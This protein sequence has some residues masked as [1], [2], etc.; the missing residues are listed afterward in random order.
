MLSPER[1]DQAGLVVERVW[2]RHR[3]R[4]SG[5]HR[6]ANEPSIWSCK[7]IQSKQKALTMVPLPLCSDPLSIQ[8]TWTHPGPRGT[9]RGPH[10]RR[11]QVAGCGVSVVDSC[12]SVW[13]GRAQ[14]ELQNTTDSMST[15]IWPVA[16]SCSWKFSIISTLRNENSSMMNWCDLAR[17]EMNGPYTKGCGDMAFRDDVRHADRRGRK[18]RKWGGTFH[19]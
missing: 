9:E 10:L 19:P 7:L 2:H 14:A 4:W 15:I 11:L 1:S 17:F 6:S 16:C 12:G 3:T 5:R 18:T 8:Q 13:A